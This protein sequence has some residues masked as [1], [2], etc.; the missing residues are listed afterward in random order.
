MITDATYNM[1][2]KNERMDMATTFKRYSLKRKHQWQKLDC[3]PAKGVYISVRQ[4][5]P[6]FA[7]KLAN[8]YIKWLHNLYS[9]ITDTVWNMPY[10]N[11]RIDMAAHLTL[12][13]DRHKRKCQWQ[14]FIV[15]R[16]KAYIAVH[17]R[18]THIWLKRVFFCAVPKRNNNTQ[19]HYMHMQIHNFK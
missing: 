12:K 3:K 1:P 9:F 7:I 15:K 11:K 2:Y 13:K 17:R 5:N 14:I 4:R 8:G 18:K 6:I 16:P 10:K 19:I